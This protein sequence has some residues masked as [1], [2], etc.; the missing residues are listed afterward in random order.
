MAKRKSTRRT[1][2]RV[3]VKR[4]PTRRL[5]KARKMKPKTIVVS[6]RQ[7]G[8]SNKAI[9]KRMKALPAGKRISK[10]GNI[11]YERRANRSDLNQKTQL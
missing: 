4:T 6:K 7:T 1:R 9:D 2:V 3:V 10:N 5:T 11:Y 8:T